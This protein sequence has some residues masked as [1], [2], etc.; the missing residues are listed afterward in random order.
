MTFPLWLSL[1]VAFCAV[2]WTHTIYYLSLGPYS[3]QKTHDWRREASHRWQSK[4]RGADER[5]LRFRRISCKGES[6]RHFEHTLHGL[7]R[8]Y[9]VFFFF[10]GKQC[11]LSM[12]LLFAVNHPIQPAFYAK[13][14]LVNFINWARR[15]KREIS[16]RYPLQGLSC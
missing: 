9:T 11:V 8:S 5:N 3:I 7:T 15:R 10:F 6:D 4:H 14:F 2:F 16:A 13:R 12:V 1:F